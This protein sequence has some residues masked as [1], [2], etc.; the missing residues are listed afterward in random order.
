[1]LMM[2]FVRELKGCQTQERLKTKI[3]NVV[4]L[5]LIPPLQV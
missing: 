2:F 1:M 4:A 3:R 5:N